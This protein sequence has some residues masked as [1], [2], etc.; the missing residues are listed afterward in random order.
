[1]ASKEDEQ[2]CCWRAEKFE[3]GSMCLPKGHRSMTIDTPPEECAPTKVGKFEDLPT[4][5]LMCEN[6][7]A[8]KEYVTVEGCDHCFAGET[9]S[10]TVTCQNSKLIAGEQLKDQQCDANGNFPEGPT[11]QPTTVNDFAPCRK[12]STGGHSS[13]CGNHTE[14]GIGV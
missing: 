11:C 4:C 5:K 3:D 2:S 6:K 1:V 7:F 9:C 12:P 8:D 13:S 14:S 10:C